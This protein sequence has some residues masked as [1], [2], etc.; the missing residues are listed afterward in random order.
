LSRKYETKIKKTTED[1]HMK[2]LSDEQVVGAWLAGKK[3]ADEDEETSRALVRY[4]LASIKAWLLE[5]RAE[6]DTSGVP[7]LGRY[8]CSH[9]ETIDEL[10]G[11]V[12]RE[13]A[14]QPEV[15]IGREVSV[16]KCPAATHEKENGICCCHLIGQIVKVARQVSPKEIKP[17]LYTIVG[18]SGLLCSNGFELLPEKP[19]EVE[20]PEDL[21]GKSVKIIRCGAFHHENDNGSCACSL[22][23]QTLIITSAIGKSGLYRLE[24]IDRAVAR[25]EFEL[26][27]VQSAEDLV[28]TD[29]GNITAE[30]Q[31]SLIGR[32]V[33][34][35]SCSFV[36]EHHESYRHCVHSLIGETVKLSSQH[37]LSGL[38]E[39]EGSDKLI[40]ASD[41]D[42]VGNLPAEVHNSP[43]TGVADSNVHKTGISGCL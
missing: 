23:G 6:K 10:M 13:I 24:R 43:S 35:K 27:P 32:Q 22:I 28:V 42:L 14:L 19:V 12:N 33:L 9:V 41:V 2:I 15:I 4:R 25:N 30:S 34:V 20:N 21:V 8:L 31:D 39:I 5:K 38:Y 11:D 40:S 37:T 26:L 36:G 1:Y 29:A 17:K 3:Q 7:Q 16:T 18:N